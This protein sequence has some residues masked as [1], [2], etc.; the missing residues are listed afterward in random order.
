MEQEERRPGV[1]DYSLCP[2]PHA[3]IKVHLGN[4][5]NPGLDNWRAATRN[6]VE[7]LRYE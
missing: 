1:A 7:A 3:K 5:M 6:P 4:Q 2:L